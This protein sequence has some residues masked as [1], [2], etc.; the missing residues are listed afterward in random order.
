MADIASTSLPFAPSPALSDTVVAN[1]GGA[2]SRVTLTAVKTALGVVAAESAAAAAQGAANSAA[3]AAAAA[4]QPGHAHI[5]AN[6]TDLV[7]FIHDTVASLLV[8]G[9]NVTLT[10][11]DVAGT[12]TVASAGGGGGGTLADGSYGDVTVSGSGTVISVNANAV[13]FSELSGRPTT[14]SGY[15]ITDAA[16]TSHTQLAGTITDFTEAVQDVVGALVTAAGGT[17]NDAAGSITFPGG[18]GATNLAFT[19]DATTVT[20]TSDTGNDA[21]LPAATASLAGVLS[22]A[23]KAKLDAI[24]SGVAVVSASRAVAPTDVGQALRVNN[25]VALTLDTDSMTTDGDL[26]YLVPT[27]GATYTLVVGTATL[28]TRTGGAALAGGS[29][30]SSA[31]ARVGEIV[32]RRESDGSYLLLS[33][34]Q[35]EVFAAITAT[36]TFPNRTTER[37]ARYFVNVASGNVTLTIASGQFPADT[38]MFG[39]EIVVLGGGSNTCTVAA[40]AGVTLQVQG[41]ATAGSGKSIVVRCDPVTANAPR[42]AA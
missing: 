41:A 39:V 8:Q 15:G 3:A 33:P 40:G 2:T 14:L 26:L 32:V 17:Y 13:A 1:V 37:L 23:D 20:V 10:Y 36:G 21:T 24:R 38:Q 29:V 31:S 11:N 42:V 18:A 30:I 25:S 34:A 22:A 9:A 35:N 19:R 12:L 27:I 7:E 6:V 4:S 16:A 5:A 28:R